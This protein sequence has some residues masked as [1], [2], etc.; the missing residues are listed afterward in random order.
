MPSKAPFIYCFTHKIGHPNDMPC[1]YCEKDR[2][3][4]EK[5][6]KKSFIEWL[7]GIFNAK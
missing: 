3:A 5:Y 2:H 1:P 4:A 7:R 6:K